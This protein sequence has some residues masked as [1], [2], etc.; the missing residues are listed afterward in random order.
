MI[1]QI[2]DSPP[3]LFK[4]RF[5]TGATKDTIMNNLQNEICELAQGYYFRYIPA[6][7][8][9]LNSVNAGI[10]LSYLLYWHGKGMRR[11]GFV[12]K[13]ITEATSETGLTRY[14]QDSAI[15]TL[16]KYELIEMKRSGSHGKRHFRIERDVLVLR[17]MPLLETSKHKRQRMLITNNAV[18]GK[19]PNSH[20][21]SYVRKQQ[22]I[23]KNTLQLNT[24]H[25]IRAS[26]ANAVV[27]GAVI[28]IR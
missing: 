20:T 27:E 11:D 28:D 4:L 12:F 3:Y 21:S 13:T 16:L 17:L 10:F 23:T 7:S 22:T 26:D 9:A 5:F 6:L 24:P 14:Q 19:P 8:L 2:S 15:K 18:R 1:L 25:K